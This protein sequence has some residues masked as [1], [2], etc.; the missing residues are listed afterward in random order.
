MRLE[1]KPV[2]SAEGLTKLLEALRPDVD[3]LLGDQPYVRRVEIEN[4]LLATFAGQAREAKRKR[5]DNFY[6]AHADTVAQVVKQLAVWQIPLNLPN[7]CHLELRHGTELVVLPDYLGLMRLATRHPQ[8]TMLRCQ[9]VY[10]SDKFSM[11][12]GVRPDIQHVVNTTAERQETDV[13]GAYAMAILEG[14][15]PPIVEYMTKA[16]IDKARSCARGDAVWNL[17][18][19]EMARKT[20]ARRLSKRL[21]GMLSEHPSLDVL[22]QAVEA[23]DLA[24]P[25]T[26]DVPQDQMPDAT[27]LHEQLREAPTRHA[28]PDDAVEA[29]A[30]ST[31]PADYDPP[32]GSA[33]AG[34]WMVWKACHLLDPSDPEGVLAEHLAPHGLEVHEL[35]KLNLDDLKELARAVR[36]ALDQ[37]N[38]P[39][40]VALE[41]L[42]ATDLQP[43]PWNEKENSTSD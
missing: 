29:D 43:M 1:R 21:P 27:A 4:A 42:D 37:P 39:G 12:A 40:T 23:D 18:Y 38:Q 10:A 25:P 34:R 5:R 20:V 7:M 16:E 36:E 15:E 14:D 24:V 19:G 26:M 13:V 2:G 3:S 30:E 35:P 8:I 32:K 31:V 9:V 6:A 22:A 11:T 28:A 33:A 17:W 41:D